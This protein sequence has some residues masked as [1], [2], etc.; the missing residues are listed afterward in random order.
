MVR[1]ILRGAASLLGLVYLAV[2]AAAQVE[3][4]VP[5]ALELMK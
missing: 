3:E 2:V 1:G 5:E 4:L